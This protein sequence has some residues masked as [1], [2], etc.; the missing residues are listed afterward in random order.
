MGKALYLLVSV[1]S[2]NLCSRTLNRDKLRYFSLLA[3][4]YVS[5]VNLLISGA[6][7]SSIGRFI[8]E[9]EFYVPM[10]LMA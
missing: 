5:L 1:N 3:L 6:E 9:G 4:A 10:S 7:H 8:I 2:E